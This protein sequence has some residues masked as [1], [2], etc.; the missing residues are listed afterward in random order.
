MGTSV[1]DRFI[2]SSHT[3][4]QLKDSVD[5]SLTALSHVWHTRCTVYVFV[6]FPHP[7]QPLTLTHL[8]FNFSPP[9][10]GNEVCLKPLWDNGELSHGRVGLSPEEHQLHVVS[11]SVFH[12]MCHPLT[13]LLHDSPGLHVWE[14]G[15]LGVGSVLVWSTW[16]VRVKARLYVWISEDWHWLVTLL[17]SPG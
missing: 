11:S 12:R 3:P 8:P 1:P 4:W 5:F 16:G 17:L 7:N 9:T 2:F 14:S 6:F 10:R 15:W 13:L